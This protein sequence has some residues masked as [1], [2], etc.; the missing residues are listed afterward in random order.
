MT[1]SLLLDTHIVVWWLSESKK[2][3]GQQLKAIRDAVHY[4]E[5]LA[6]S[7]ITLLEIAVLGR[8]QE[9]LRI[10][11]REILAELDGNLDF[12]IIPLDLQLAVEI[13][14]MGD[15]LRDPSDRAIV[16]TARVHRLR[17]VTSDQRI[18]HSNL[19]RVVE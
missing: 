17:L 1:S 10:S 19:V 4:G 3:S 2:L 16:A 5:Q 12:R 8:R 15:S 14:A 6:L 9:S 7:A 13:E 18:I 11:A